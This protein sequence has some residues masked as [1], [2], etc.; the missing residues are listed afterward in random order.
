VAAGAVVTKHVPA[1]TLVAEVARPAQA[2]TEPWK[3]LLPSGK[4]ALPV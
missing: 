1:R 2:R 4:H 3:R